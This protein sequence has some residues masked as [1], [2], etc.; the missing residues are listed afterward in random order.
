MNPP[1]F[2]VALLALGALSAPTRP[3]RAQTP[4]PPPAA[5]TLDVMTFNIRSSA[6]PDGDDAWA[7]R[8]ELVAETIARA[9]PEIVGLQEVLREQTAFLETALPG[10]RWLGVD[11]GLNGGTGLSESTPI[12]YRADVLVPLETGTFWLGNPPSPG[13]GGRG[14]QGG[15]GGRGGRGGR[16]GSRIVTWAH[17]HHL[18]SGRQFW[19]YNTHLSP[20]EGPQHVEALARIQE[21]IAALPPGAA[22]ILMGDFNSTAGMSEAWKAATEGGLRDVWTIAPVREGPPFTSNGFGPPPA[23]GDWRIDWILVGGPIEAMSASTVVRSAGG[24]YPSDHYPVLATLTILP[25]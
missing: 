8:K 1:R 25:H 12:W 19:V 4:A 21:R 18:D 6:I 5:V 15:Q 11:R 7:S 14:T 24:R 16:G 20:R 17:F 10:Y 23:E 3:A 9:G 2:L 13:D 22:V